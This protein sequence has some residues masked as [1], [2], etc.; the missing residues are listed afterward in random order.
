M[1]EAQATEDERQRRVWDVVGRIPKGRV[2]AY[3]EVARLAGLPG[4]ARYVGYVMRRL[5]KGSKLPW[6]RVVNAQ[7]RLSFPPGSD[8]Y[9]RQKS[10]LEAEGVIFS[11]ERLS[12]KRYGWV[13]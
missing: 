3:G 12:L 2:L 5:P 8:S 13:P 4:H 10:R 9:K 1:A 6:H 11:N 7:G